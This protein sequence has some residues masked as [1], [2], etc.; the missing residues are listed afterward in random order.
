MF[1]PQYQ[2][3]SFTPI[4]ITGKIIV[5]KMHPYKLISLDASANSQQSMLHCYLQWCFRLP[6]QNSVSQP[7]QRFTAWSGIHS[8][9]PASRSSTASHDTSELRDSP[10]EGCSPLHT[11]SGRD[12]F[13]TVQSNMSDKRE[14]QHTGHSM[15]SEPMKQTGPSL[16]LFILGRLEVPREV[17]KTVHFH[18]FIYCSF[19]LIAL[20]KWRNA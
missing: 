1:L 5:L 9:G 11:D 10:A 4:Q 16:I 3:P 6:S 17:W 12:P 7:M 14:Y 8:V 13:S 18:N 20:W 19:S 2:R 15:S